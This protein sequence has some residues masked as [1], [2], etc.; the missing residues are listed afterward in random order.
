MADALAIWM[1]GTKVAIITNE[2]RRLRLAYTQEGRLA[3]PGGTPL[4]SLKLPVT[5]E[6]Y[7]NNLVRSFLDGLLPEGEARRVIAEDMSIQANDTFE[8]IAAIGRDCAGA[9]ILQNESAPPPPRSSVQ[10]AEPITND[11]LAKLVA[12]LRG[13]PLGIDHRVRI[14]LAG[15]QEKLLLTRLPD[16]S[17]GRP[18]DGTPSTHILKPEIRGYPH[19][20]ENEA[21]CMRVAAYLGLRVAHI[22]TAEV[23][24][25]RLLVVSR[26]DREIEPSGEVRR[27]HQEDMCQATGVAPKDKYQASGGPSLRRIAA[28]LADF[29]PDS[30]TRLLQA[31]TI[32]VLLGNGDA[33]AKNYSL[34]HQANGLITLAPL[35]DVMSTL[36]YGDDRLAMLVDGVHRSNRVTGERLLNE[37]VSWGLSHS[38]SV[39][40]I[41]DLV[42][43]IRGA[44]EQAALETPGV[45]NALIEVVESQAKLVSFG[46]MSSWRASI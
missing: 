6:R 22:E 28:I 3:F 10:S 17:W 44:S 31:V 18:V 36:I 9:I 23:D 29:D 26:Y 25:R 4:L 11:E 12:N 40:V 19:T 24:G 46:L 33:H 21:F 34:L 39:E 14:S 15:I 8:L 38:A 45:P 1:Y 41:Q 32:H 30:L 7:T 5:D 27:I 13:A 2:R 16:G 37:A 43:R 20:V 42:D 35:Y